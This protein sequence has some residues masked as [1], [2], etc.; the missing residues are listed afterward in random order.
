M[1]M[2]GCYAGAHFLCLLR[3]VIAD[4]RATGD[5]SYHADNRCTS[6]AKDVAG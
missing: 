6:Q 5:T 3:I 1:A 4:P 2:P